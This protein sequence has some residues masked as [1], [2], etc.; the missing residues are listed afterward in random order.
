MGL[1]L[2]LSDRLPRSSGRLIA[3]H[4]NYR[5][6]GRDSDRDENL[7]A[8]VCREKGIPLRLWRIEGFR[9]KARREKRSLQDYAR[10]VRYRFF[11]K[12][13]ALTRASGVAVAHQLEDQAETVLDR[14]LRGAGP[15]GLTGL[16]ELQV[17]QFQQG[18]PPLRV[19]R[20]LLRLPKKDL[21]DLLTRRGIRWREDSSNRRDHYRRNQ[22]RHLVIP[23]LKRWNPNLEGNLARTGE[24]ASA[25][26][27]LLEDLA[28]DLGP[29]LGLKERN[30]QTR[31]RADL[32]QKEPL[33]LQRRWIRR[34]AED[35]DPAARGLSFDRVQEALE[36]WKGAAQG[37]RDLGYGLLVDRV[38]DLGIL[39]RVPMVAT[40]KTQKTRR[41]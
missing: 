20:P 30:G 34:L 37:P 29:R 10:E 41:L 26:D 16:R 23:F 24:I 18:Y 21:R 25:E 22:I 14:L 3:A 4:V 32:F 6:R 28:K 35:L 2:L 36:V 17:L 7:V 15:R 39:R 1:L 5:L 33:A 40:V 31:F 19:W 27:S 9:K 13:V 38:K 12:V 8:E 11:Q